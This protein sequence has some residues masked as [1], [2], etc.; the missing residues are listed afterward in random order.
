MPVRYT[1]GYLTSRRITIDHP[2]RVI[3]QATPSLINF[4]S[5][6]QASKIK[7]FPRQRLNTTKR[8]FGWKEIP[9]SSDNN[10]SPPTTSSPSQ[11]SSPVA[12]KRKITRTRTGCQT[13][14]DRKVKCGEEKPSCSNCQ[15]TNHVC[16]GYA[17]PTIFKPVRKGRSEEQ[18]DRRT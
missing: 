2:G 7:L 5:H 16:P 9:S 11:P 1:S 6:R 4:V 13:C 17:P 10:N 8:W 18:Y 15:R 12:R 3:H 14:R